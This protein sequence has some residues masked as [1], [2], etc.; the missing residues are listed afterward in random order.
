[1]QSLIGTREEVMMSERPMSGEN[2]HATHGCWRWWSTAR[3]PRFVVP[4]QWAQRWPWPIWPLEAPGARALQPLSGEPRSSPVG[5]AI[6]VAEMMSGPAKAV[7]QNNFFRFGYC[8]G[9]GEIVHI[10]GG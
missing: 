9:G 6:V 8:P 3:S 5:A 7:P 10:A 4:V 1:M 2:A